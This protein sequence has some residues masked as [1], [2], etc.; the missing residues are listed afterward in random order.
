MSRE[1]LSCI[2]GVL[3]IA[4]F[5][6]SCKE[7]AQETKPLTRA[8][9]T[10]LNPNG[11]SELAK[12]MREMAS[13][14]ENTRERLQKGDSLLPYPEH[15]IQIHTAQ[16]T[17]DMVDEQTMRIMGSSYLEG[18]RMLY[19]ASPDARKENFNV[20]VNA[21]VACHEYVCPGPLKRIGKLSIP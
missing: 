16:S 9:S 6:I 4:L 10:S 18:L 7:Q 12:L 19:K 13:F 20:A 2:A 8:D 11:D 17:P 1:Q 15:F 3:A 14:M 21:C 5:F